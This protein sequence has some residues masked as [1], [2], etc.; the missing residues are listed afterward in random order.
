MSLSSIICAHSWIFV[1]ESFMCKYNLNQL[2]DLDVPSRLQNGLVTNLH[3]AK[4]CIK[5]YLFRIN[6]FCLETKL[7]EARPLFL[8][9]GQFAN[10][11]KWFVVV[12]RKNKGAVSG[13]QCR[14][15]HAAFNK[16][17][18]PPPPLSSLFKA[19]PSSVRVWQV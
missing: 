3:C 6:K 1:A 7:T 12:G 14:L 4:T 16:S 2:N 17:I 5:E 13:T 8:T 15:P 18:S 10:A 11:P 9:T 19:T